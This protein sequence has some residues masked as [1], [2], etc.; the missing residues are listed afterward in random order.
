MTVKDYQVEAVMAKSEV[1]REWGANWVRMILEAAAEAVDPDEVVVTQEMI[2]MGFA[3]HGDGAYFDPAK[4]YTAM[5]AARPKAEDARAGAPT[6]YVPAY[7]R[8]FPDKLGHY[9]I[10]D[11]RKG[12]RRTSH[13]PAA[14]KGLLGSSGVC[15]VGDRRQGAGR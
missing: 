6:P 2:V 12:D 7:L 5:H 3:A 4:V 15:R 14:M 8:A 11:T 1:C 10:Q 9:Y 13:S